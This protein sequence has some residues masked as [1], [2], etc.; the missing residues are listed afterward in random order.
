MAPEINQ[1]VHVEG[2]RVGVE[3]CLAPSGCDFEVA[4]LERIGRLQGKSTSELPAYRG[5]ESIA[6]ADAGL[7]GTR[8]RLI[9]QRMI[10]T[11]T[12]R[13]GDLPI[14][15]RRTRSKYRKD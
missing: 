7:R 10:C 1:Q 15:R 9:G 6:R 13:T 3:R 4:I 14:G 2:V 8:R 5:L 11:E 12:G